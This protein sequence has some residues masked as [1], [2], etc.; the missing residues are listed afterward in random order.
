M[1]RFNTFLN[2]A[3]STN[4]VKKT[5]PSVFHLSHV[6]MVRSNAPSRRKCAMSLKP[7]ALVRQ[8]QRQHMVNQSDRGGCEDVSVF[9]KKVRGFNKIQ[10]TRH[11]CLYLIKLEQLTI[12]VA[13]LLLHFPVVTSLHTINFLGC[14]L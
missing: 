3:G 4:P 9:T 1:L 7:K 6:R 5:L 14:S 11:S 8:H 12:I 10:T 2:I 13:L